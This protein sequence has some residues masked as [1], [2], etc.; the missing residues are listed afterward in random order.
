VRD[1]IIGCSTN[2][3]WSKLK[4]WINSINKSGFEG[5]K[6][7]VLMNCDSVTVQKVVDSGFGVIGFKK[8]ED[9]SLKHE[10]NMPVHTERFIH[11]YNYLKDRDY[12]F[13]ITTDVKDVVFQKNPIEYLEKECINKNLVFASESIRYKDEPWGDKNLK[14]TFGEYVY[15][16][17]K[18]EEIFN[19]G[20]LAGHGYAIRDLALNIFLS[21][22]NR[23]IP[24]CDQSTFNVMV[25]RNP[26]LPMSKY[27]R[28]E[29]GWAAQLGTTGDPTKSKEFDSV[30]LEPKPKLKDGVV[31]TSTGEEFYIV[32]QYD[33]VPEMKKVI[34]EKFA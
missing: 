8:E 2:Y 28:S 23:P 21:C 18:N 4:Y 24:I 14:D 5:D 7:L 30:L 16:H 9:G 25:S 11:I 33:R 22:T 15:E 1:L 6:V 19:V 34:E 32:H 31:T 29:E 20:V 12:R 13:V 17:F 3:D 10:S 27:A 26:Y